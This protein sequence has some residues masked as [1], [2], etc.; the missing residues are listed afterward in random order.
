MA[1]LAFEF[2][3]TSFHS[4]GLILSAH[5]S[6]AL[7]AGPGT[8]HAPGSGGHLTDP[9]QSVLPFVCSERLSCHLW[10]PLGLGPGVTRVDEPP[11]CLQG[12]CGPG[13]RTCPVRAA[14][15]EGAYSPGLCLQDKNVV[16]FLPEKS[17]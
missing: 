3:A 16:L 2:R 12:G 11:A 6:S 9:E 7:K 8:T 13:R 1:D 15:Q 10:S 4:W 5:L 14:R 17:T